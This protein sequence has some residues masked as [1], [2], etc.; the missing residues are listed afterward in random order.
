MIIRS[1]QSVPKSIVLLLIVGFAT[2]AFWHTKQHP[3][4][5]HAQALSSPPRAFVLKVASIGEPIA[6]SKSL[7]LW[8]QAFDNQPGLSIP[9]RELDYSKVV[10][11]LEVIQEL[12]NRGQYPLLAASRLYSEV[13]DQAR[14]RQMLEFVYQQFFVDPERRWPWLTHAAI[15]AKH[16]LHDLPLAL[17]FSKAIADKSISNKNIPSWVRQMPILILQEMGELESARIIIGGLLESGQIT[18]PHELRFL[19]QRLEMLNQQTTGLN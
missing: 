11:W 12:D 13:P 2:Q 8:L 5:A 3:P 17:K 9:F 6:L 15:I 18:D 14:Q 16:R 1:I 7:M 19:N 4:A 10:A